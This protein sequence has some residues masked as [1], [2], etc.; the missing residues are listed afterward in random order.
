V[1]LPAVV[2]LRPGARA[3]IPQLRRVG[4]DALAIERHFLNMTGA[5]HPFVPTSRSPVT[6]GYGIWTSSPGWANSTQLLF[7]GCGTW[8]PRYRANMRLVDVFKRSQ[9]RHE[10]HFRGSR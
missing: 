5:I 8:D 9:I 6:R 2:R 3:R 4:G 7:L 10:F 1:E